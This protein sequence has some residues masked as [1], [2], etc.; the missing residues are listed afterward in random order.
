[1][2]GRAHTATLRRFAGAKIEP[3]R[4]HGLR[5]DH[6]AL[7]EGRTIFP[8]SVVG[9]WES[10]RFLVSGHNNPKLGR[11]VMKGPRTG[12]PIFHVTLEERAT[13]PRSC[14]QWSTCYGNTMPYARRHTPDA[15]FLAAFKAEVI[16]VARAYPKGL[17][18]R[19]H[20]LGDFFSLAYVE[21]WAGLLKILPQL[22]VFGYT[23]RSEEADDAESRAIA[24]AIRALTE[25]S[26][27]RF[28]IRFSRVEPGPQHSIVVDADPGLADVIV[29]P[30]QTGA[31]EAC[32]TCG[33]C[34]AAGAREKTIAF[35]RHGMK[36]NKGKARKPKAPIEPRVP[37]P[38]GRPRKVPLPL[39]AA[40]PA[41]R[42]A[43]VNNDERQRIAATY[44]AKFERR[45]G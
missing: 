31:T 45:V 28:A 15:D 27:E 39:V 29:C 33:L 44:G 14:A 16:T 36:S 10:P 9:T 12:W 43:A 5:A 2:R 7:A 17:L 21:A 40:T 41:D 32:A 19:L 26:W 42:I 25:T 11:A 6:E 4:S 38:R 30:A 3:E 13:C 23:A 18:I 22:H 8:T 34:W 1:M 37:R 35:L 20:A 24:A